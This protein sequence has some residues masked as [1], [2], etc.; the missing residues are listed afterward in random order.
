MRI[1][2][3]QKQM[4]IKRILKSGS[5]INEMFNL[6]FVTNNKTLHE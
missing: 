6:H 5:K 3:E 1:I 4:R 2:R